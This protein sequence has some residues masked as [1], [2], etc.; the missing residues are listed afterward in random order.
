MD[1]RMANYDQ[2]Q[3]SSYERQHRRRPRREHERHDRRHHRRHHHNGEEEL[4][5]PQQHVLDD[6][7][8]RRTGLSHDPLQ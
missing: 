2:R 3:I 1:P 8:Q 4:S 7:V 5:G 6:M